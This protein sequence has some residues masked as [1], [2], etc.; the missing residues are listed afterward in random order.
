MEIYFENINCI[1]KF[2]I[3]SR[4]RYF[5]RYDIFNQISEDGFARIVHQAEGSDLIFP[6]APSIPA[7]PVSIVRYP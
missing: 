7:D 4:K 6:A 5:C 2:S 3:N 1:G